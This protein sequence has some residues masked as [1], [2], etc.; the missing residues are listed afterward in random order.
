M[1]GVDE[2]H[3]RE[4][5]LRAAAEIIRRHGHKPADMVWT[6]IEPVAIAAAA[7]NGVVWD[8]LAGSQKLRYPDWCALVHRW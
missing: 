6:D 4:G 7:V 5:A 2:F 1:G 8:L 3:D